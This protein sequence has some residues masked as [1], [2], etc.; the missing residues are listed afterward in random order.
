MKSEDVKA[1]VSYRMEKSEEAIKAAE[2]L[3][4]N[5]V[6][7]RPSEAAKLNFNYLRR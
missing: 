6:I 4:K 2:I 7:Y 3:L 5:F 1:L